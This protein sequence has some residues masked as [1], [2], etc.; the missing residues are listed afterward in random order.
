[1]AIAALVRRDDVTAG[2]GERQHHLAPAVG[3]LREA[4][5]EEKQRTVRAVMAGLQNVHPQ[6]VDAGDKARADAVGQGGGGQRGEIDHGALLAVM[7]P[8]S[9]VCS[10]LRTI[11]TAC[12]I[13]TM[14]LPHDTFAMSAYQAR[15]FSGGG[16]FCRVSFRLC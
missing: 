3:E 14:I 4:M 16:S 12:P 8:G 11:M 2:L 7:P 15:I 13:S 10:E 6:A 5:E 1:A 9:K